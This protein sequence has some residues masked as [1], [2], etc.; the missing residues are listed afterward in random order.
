M[1]CNHHQTLLEYVK[2]GKPKGNR[3]LRSWA[4]V[5]VNIDRG[6][7]KTEKG[8]DWIQLAQHT[9]KWRLVETRRSTFRFH[10]VRGISR[11]PEQVLGS[12]EGLLP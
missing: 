2:E 1:I 11:L 6:L 7:Q 10:N 5:G 12:Q 4:C 3:S 9:C 8:M